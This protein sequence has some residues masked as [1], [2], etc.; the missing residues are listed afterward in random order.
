MRRASLL[1]SAIVVES[2]CERMGIIV[3]AMINGAMDKH[4]FYLLL[5][6]LPLIEI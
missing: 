2:P 4:I 5:R 6:E 3:V 1:E